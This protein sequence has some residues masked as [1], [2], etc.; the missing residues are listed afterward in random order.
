MKAAGYYKIRVGIETLDK[1]NMELLSKNKMK[2][3]RDKLMEVLY[4]CKDIGIKVY[5]TLSVGTYGSSKEKDKYTI[6]KIK[7]FYEDGLIQEYSV[8]INTPMPGTPF[9]DLCIENNWINNNAKI[10]YDGNKDVII[11]YP[12]YS[13]EE[14]SESFR[15]AKETISQIIQ[16]NRNEKNIRYT[17][18][19]REWCK[20][21]Y[22]TSN[23]QIG[24][25]ILEGE[26]D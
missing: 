10:N 11:N 5:C 6:D 21:V 1:N 25:G 12:N 16:T 22:D 14:I 17:V 2:S 19:D 4:A 9:Y 7:E 3:N 18:Y 15:Y 20:I 24:Q 26:D 8:S 23:R 13:F